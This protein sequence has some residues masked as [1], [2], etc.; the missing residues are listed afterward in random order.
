MQRLGAQIDTVESKVDETIARTNQNTTCIES[1]Q[2]QLE[3]TLVKIDDLGNRSRRYNFHICGLPES[4]KD[5]DA[6]VHTFLKD[7]LP[8]LSP[9]CLDLYRAH[10]ALQPPPHPKGPPQDI[11]VKPHYYMTKELVMQK[12]TEASS[13]SLLGHNNQ[14]FGD[15]S[16]FTAQKG[17]TM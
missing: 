8:D 15:I 14:V 5:V 3:Q 2:Q 13:L 9:H 4:V 12:A 16:P 6:A 7:L 11:I 10:R 1:L 17:R